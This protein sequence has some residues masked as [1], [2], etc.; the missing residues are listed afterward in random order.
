MAEPFL[1]SCFD[2]CLS[3]EIELIE[4]AQADAGDARPV[5]DIRLGS[6]PE[7]LAGAEPARFGIQSL[8]DEVLLSVTGNARY[9]VRGGREIIV[10]PAPAGSERNVRLFLLG[11]ALGILCH[12]RG[13]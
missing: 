2:F 4:L 11:S 7:A 1:Y 8:G 6:V 5:V 10:D 13:L 12:Q 9:L 3:S